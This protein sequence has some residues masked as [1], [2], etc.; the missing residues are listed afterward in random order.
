MIA[1]GVDNDGVSL[2]NVLTRPI[3]K[4]GA[5]ARVARALPAIEQRLLERRERARV[6]QVLQL[7]A[8]FSKQFSLNSRELRNALK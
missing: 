1:R 5:V 6:G 3:D 8:L 2:R 4:D 7:N